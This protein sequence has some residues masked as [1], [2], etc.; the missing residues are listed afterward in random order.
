MQWHFGP[1]R[2]DHD[3][4]CVWRGEQR[5]ALRPKT[6]ELLVHLVQHAG[7]LV[8]KEALF[9]AVWPDAV[10]AEGVLATSMVELRKAL[11]ETARQPQ[12]IATVHRRG[13]RFIAPVVAIDPVAP[14]STPLDLLD[15]STPPPT[16]ALPGLLVSRAAELAALHACLAHA[17]Q[18]E[19]QVVFIT[20]E[21]G[22]GKTTLVDAFVSQMAS[23][24][25]PWVG[26][27]QCIEQYGAGEPY[28]PLFEALGGLCRSPD[29]THLLA[30][31]TQQAPSW[32][33]QMPALLSTAEY[34]TLQR[35]VAGA[36]RERMLRELAEAVEALTTERPLVLVLEDLHWSD[37]STLEWLAYVARRR[38]SARLLVLGTYRP[39]DAIVR[40]HPVRGMTQELLVHGQCQQVVVG[41]LSAAQVGAYLT[42]RF[43]AGPLGAT[44]APLLHQRT[45]GNPLF[46]VTMVDEMVRQGVLRAGTTGWE[47]AAGAD[48]V[49]LAAPESVWTC[50]PNSSSSS[51]AMSRCCSKPQV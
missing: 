30:R 43:G 9:E 17:L 26:R 45:N 21:A 29:G 20:G 41:Y 27:G 32:L 40:E 10:V 12:F 39:S 38:Q 49:T 4:A 28:L 44:I 3:N 22:I 35:R 48:V 14:E 50:S 34:D 11:G 31:L 25:V 1:F 5:L 8:T 46:L 18:G 47:V 36:S 37:A 19:R 6:F 15:V 33:I 23:A 13:Y 7:V 51:H 2:L 16:Y 24:P 42:L